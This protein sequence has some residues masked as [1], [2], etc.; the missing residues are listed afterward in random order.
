MMT[1]KVLSALLIYPEQ[2]VVDGLDEMAAILDREKLLPGAV[3]TDLRALMGELGATELMEAQGRYISL[4]DQSRSLSLH[5]FEH[6]HGESRDRG[7]AMVDLLAHYR[8]K[9]LDL[10]TVELP[11]YLPLFLEF[12]SMQPLEDARELLGETIDI[13][14]LLR[15]RLEKR[16]SA[17]AA[18]LRA[19][20]ALA[21]HRIDGHAL[22]ETVDGETP[23]DTPEALDRTWEEAPVTFND[24]SLEQAS[25][26]GCSAAA[27]IVDRF[28]PP[29]N[30]PQAASRERRQASGAQ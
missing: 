17:Y 5:L 28:A 20:E 9:D 2:E 27:A 29:G 10:T 16:R 22:R 15:A 23:D 8:S 24:A 3:M 6:I 1:F 25:G 4:F 21:P 7:Q 26:G 19:I 13:V 14:A 12:L 18:V 11:D 30:P